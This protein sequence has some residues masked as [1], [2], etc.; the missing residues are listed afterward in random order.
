M[1]I[2]FVCTG[3]ICR[4]PLAEGILRSRYDQS[5]LKGEIDSCGFESFHVGDPPDQ[6]A[7]TVARQRGIDISAHRARLFT[8]SDF[9]RFDRI[10]VMDASHYQ[11]VMRRARNESDRQKTDFLMNV[12]APGKN[13]PVPDPWYHDITAF[14]EVYDQVARACDKIASMVMQTNHLNDNH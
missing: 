6:R 1:N 4:S 14:E 10:F 12:I 2:L 5:G 9:D 3:N 13:Q 7:Q 8:P 11:N